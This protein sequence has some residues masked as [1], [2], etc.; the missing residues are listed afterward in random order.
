MNQEG[1]FIIC[2]ACGFKWGDLNDFLG[3]TDIIITG[4]R[5]NFN[6]LAAGTFMFEHSCGATL[7]LAV[8][9]FK[10]LHEGSITRKRAI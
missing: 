9:E 1:F 5:V 2:R 4:Y 10:D 3:D 6:K 7:S 8:K